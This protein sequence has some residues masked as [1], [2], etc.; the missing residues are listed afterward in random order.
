M[1][2]FTPQPRKKIALDNPKIQLRAMTNKSKRPAT[3][4]FGLV[5][6][7]PRI[8]VY[9]NDPDDQNNDYG[10]IVAKLDLMTLYGLMEMIKIALQKTEKWNDKVDCKEFPWDRNNNRR[11]DTARVTAS[12]IAGR[13][14][15]GSVWL[16]VSAPTRPNIKFYFGPSEFHSHTHGDGTPYDKPEHSQLYAAAFLEIMTKLYAHLAVTEYVPPKPKE[17]KGNGYN[18]G[19]NRQSN[20]R[21]ASNNDADFS[22][23][24][25]IPW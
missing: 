6:N 20:N 23:D 22:A 19:G 18:G 12:V 14:E 11:S 17:E 15:D 8:T 9:T 4:S 24:E 3:L 25:D 7:N 21:P 13:D 1:S 5:N 2:D 10:R 16:A